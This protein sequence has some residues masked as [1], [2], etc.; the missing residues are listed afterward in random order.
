M[1]RLVAVV[2]PVS[3]SLS[4]FRVEVVDSAG[5]PLPQRLLHHLNL[6]DPGRREL[7]L[8]IGL[9]IFAASKETPAA[10][11]PW[12]LFGLPVTEGQ[13]FIASAMLSNSTPTN[14]RGIRVRLLLSYTPANRPWP[15]FRAYPWVMD[16]LFP[17]GHPPGG[18]K[19]FDLPPGRTTR[20]WVSSPA[21]PGTIVGM[22]GHIHDYGVGLEFADSTTGEVIWHGVPVRDSAGLVSSLPVT[23][24]YRWY[25]FGI[26]ITPTHR[27]RVSVVYD[28]PTGHPIPNG[29]MGAVA[30]LFMPDRGATWPPLDPNDPDYRRDL[31]D[32]L[33]PA[34]EMMDMPGHH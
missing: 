4:G 11:V 16:V 29:G 18:S 2:L 12:L 17:V 14:Y 20:S 31:L 21:V 32:T 30:G 22:G 13:R 34:E 33:H 19:A 15:L 7:F 25:R 27:Y 28:N 6:S 10:T 8:P 23:R 1:S 9:H 24:F 5:R 26:H 3:G